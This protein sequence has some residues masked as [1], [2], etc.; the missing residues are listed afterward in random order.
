MNGMS[1]L[2]GELAETI[3]DALE[4]ADLPLDC[5]LTRSTPGDGDPWNPDAGTSTDY[6]CKGFTDEYTALER[7]DSLIQ[8][9][10]IKV[11]IVATTV[12]IEPLPLDSVSIRSKTYTVVNVSTDPARALWQLQARA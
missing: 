5:V 2:D 6:A 8:A 1:I 11:V 4:A 9:D 7:A 12:A 3:A 10:D